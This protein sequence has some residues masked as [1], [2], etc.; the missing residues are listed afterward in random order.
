ML[1]CCVVIDVTI[2][3]YMFVML[4]DD[5]VLV[6]IWVTFVLSITFFQ[7]VSKYFWLTILIFGYL[8]NLT[9]IEDILYYNLVDIF[10]VLLK[11]I[12]IIVQNNICINSTTMSKL[13]LH[14]FYKIVL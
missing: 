4:Y 7:G 9:Q 12:D 11:P 1:T 13:I 6:T 14:F 3:K 2:I 8:I 5:H 10:L